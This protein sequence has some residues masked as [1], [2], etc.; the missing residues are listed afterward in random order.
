[1]GAGRPRFELLLED[2]GGE[3]PAAIRLRGAL[4]RLR[5]SFGFRCLGVAEVPAPAEDSAPAEAPD[6]RQVP[7]GKPS[8]RRRLF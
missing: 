6:A 8:I 7:A 5:R 4:K 2:L 3:V 1:M